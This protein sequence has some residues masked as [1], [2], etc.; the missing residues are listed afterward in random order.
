M[1]MRGLCRWGLPCVVPAVE[2]SRFIM[3][4]HIQLMKIIPLDAVLIPEKDIF[5]SFAAAMSI[6]AVIHAEPN[7]KS[8]IPFSE[9]PAR[10]SNIHIYE[11]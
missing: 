2:L 7:M 9:K 10:F 4:H 3:V 5:T 1:R 11:K 6:I 8:A